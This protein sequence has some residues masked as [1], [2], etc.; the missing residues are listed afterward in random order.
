MSGL[1]EDIHEPR[2]STPNWEGH[3]DNEPEVPTWDALG[4]H[5]CTDV[6]WDRSSNK[7]IDSF[8]GD[9]CRTHL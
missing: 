6:G 5:R 7:E 1:R 8:L 9:Y 3:L 4:H 2:M